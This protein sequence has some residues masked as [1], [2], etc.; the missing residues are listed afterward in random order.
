M[1]TPV[2]PQLMRV[3]EVAAVWNV[4]ARTVTKWCKAGR[5]PALR[6]PTGHR[7]IPVV[8]VRVS[9]IRGGAT[10]A[11]ADARIAAVLGRQAGGS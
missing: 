7:R 10:S 5:Y 9:L 6:T 2:V 11:E 1:N 8:A 4:D 3:S